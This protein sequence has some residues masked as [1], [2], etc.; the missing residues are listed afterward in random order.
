MMSGS[1]RSDSRDTS[2]NSTSCSAPSAPSSPQHALATA[3]VGKTSDNV[4]SVSFERSR[5]EN[6]NPV[7]FKSLGKTNSKVTR[8]LM[9]MS[10]QQREQITE[11]IHG[12]HSMAIPESS[13]LISRSLACLEQAIASKVQLAQQ[14]HLSE[15]KSSSSQ[16]IP[17]FLEVQRLGAMFLYQ[18][19]FRLKFLRATLFDAALA[20]DRLLGFLQLVRDLLG[21]EALIKLPLLLNQFAFDEHG[22]L[23]EGA[24]QILP[25]R[26]R[27]GRRITAI[28]N[29][30]GP[31][32][33]LAAKVR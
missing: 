30:F 14:Q 17:A 25:G 8:E 9:Q 5:S 3:D 20:A 6:D 23:R 11:E 2:S 22:L 21:L 27:V 24:F 7:A 26:D 29:D 12:V 33:T 28:V 18:P 31:Q 32:R 10:L 19:S 15:H 13:D 16:K 1:I 4:I